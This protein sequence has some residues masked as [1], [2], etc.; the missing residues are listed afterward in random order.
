MQCPLKHSF[1]P[2]LLQCANEVVEST[3]SILNENEWRGFWITYN[4]NTGMMDVGKE[5]QAA[6]MT[7]TDPD[8][9]EV[10]YVGYS[11]GFGSEGI[12]RFCNLSK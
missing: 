8:P 3:P 4:M 6:F 5:A 12:F 11:T 10:K 9:L 7:Y 2:L 1:T